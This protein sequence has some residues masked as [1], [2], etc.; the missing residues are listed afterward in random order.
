VV[1][2]ATRRYCR[3]V[4]PIP[5]VIFVSSRVHSLMFE[6]YSVFPREVLRCMLY[7]QA[8]SQIFSL[9]LGADVSSN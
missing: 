9:F 8:T 2:I 5:V 3:G 7:N 1:A 4:E 6:R